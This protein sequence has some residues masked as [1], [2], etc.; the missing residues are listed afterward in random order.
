MNKKLL[1]V[2]LAGVMATGM[3]SAQAEPASREKCFGIAKA[4]K[5]D[6]KSADGK[7]SCAGHSDRNNDPNDWNYV[8]KGECAKAGGNLEAGQKS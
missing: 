8:A 3:V 4:G 7:F 2:A 5:N 1:C 6:C